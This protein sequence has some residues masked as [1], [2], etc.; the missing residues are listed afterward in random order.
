MLGDECS[1]RVGNSYNFLDGKREEER[2]RRRWEDDFKM[3]EGVESAGSDCSK[4][5]RFV[6][7]VMYLQVPYRMGNLLTS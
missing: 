4:I 1:R 2:L 7:T 6:N 5:A 3:C